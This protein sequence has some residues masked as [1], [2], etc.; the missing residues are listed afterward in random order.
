MQRK[1]YVEFTKGLLDRS[2][3]MSLA[4]SNGC[5]LIWC[6]VWKAESKSGGSI[7]TGPTPRWRTPVSLTVSPSEPTKRKAPAP[8]HPLRK[9]PADQGEPQAR[10]LFHTNLIVEL[11]FMMNMSDHHRGTCMDMLAFL[12]FRFCKWTSLTR[13]NN[14]CHC[15][16]VT[17]KSLAVTQ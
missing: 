6:F 1:Q 15:T 3:S 13:A 10:S 9:V 16:E 17:S 12:F 11:F 8:K 4:T 5:N 7:S 2:F 14:F